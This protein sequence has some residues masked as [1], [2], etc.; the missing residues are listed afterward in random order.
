MFLDS[1]VGDA[2]WR[3]RYARDRAG[4][5]VP[6]PLLAEEIEAKHPYA[7]MDLRGMLA[8]PYFEKALYELPEAE[9]S[10]VRVLELAD[11]IERRIQGGLGPRPLLSVPHLLSDEAS[12]YYHGYVLAE[13]AVH[14]TRRFFLDKHGFLVDNPH[15]GP[16]LEEFYW[17]A[18]NSEPFLDLVER[19]TGTALTGQAWID[20]LEEPVADLLAREGEAYNAAV[21]KVSPAEET[22][23]V[24]LDMRVRFV[25]GAEQIADSHADGSFL[26]ACRRFEEY[27][28]MRFPQ[29][30]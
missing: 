19:L 15:V 7:V 14:Q 12:C 11:E 1:L 10:S 3:G 17:R 28:K 6:F 23:G 18:G 16:I 13:M 20:A 21:K 30:A 22:G 4:K 2:A 9:L 29:T 26:A 5:P 24:D 25:D 8:V 27:V